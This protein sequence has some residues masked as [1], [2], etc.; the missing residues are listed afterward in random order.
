MGTELSRWYMRKKQKNMLLESIAAQL[1][2]I[3]REP[4]SPYDERINSL[5]STVKDFREENLSNLCSIIIYDDD[6]KRTDIVKILLSGLGNLE[7]K[8]LLYYAMGFLKDIAESSSETADQAREMIHTAIEKFANFPYDDLE[9]NEEIHHTFKWIAQQAEFAE[10]SVPE[11][12]SQT[13]SPSEKKSMAERLKLR[14]SAERKSIVKLNFSLPVINVA[15]PN[16]GLLIRN[17][18]EYI[19]R[20]SDLDKK[21]DLN[22]KATRREI[23]GQTSA[24]KSTCKLLI[25]HLNLILERPQNRS[26]DQKEYDAKKHYAPRIQNI[27]KM[28][29]MIKYWALNLQN[30]SPSESKQFQELYSQVSD[31]IKSYKDKLNIKPTIE[32]DD[33]IYLT[34]LYFSI[35]GTIKKLTET[36]KRLPA[37]QKVINLDKITAQLNQ[38]IQFYIERC[39]PGNKTYKAFQDKLVD[40]MNKLPAPD[41]TS[42]SDTQSE[43]DSPHRPHLE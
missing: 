12:T 28:E 25:E 3:K 15:Q 27:D 7:P 24:F 9:F 26:L 18:P 10:L 39:P 11:T 33:Y 32:Y 40:S 35:D 5:I 16:I 4:G 42:L 14:F 29:T 41:E 36:L 31:R 43:P 30:M 21:K 6:F 17:N 2:D 13:A 38:Q 19:L 1:N 22:N 37:D 20:I 23:K 8:P 34:K